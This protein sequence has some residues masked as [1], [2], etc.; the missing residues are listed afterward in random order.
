M[1]SVDRFG[2]ES[3]DIK[4]QNTSRNCVQPW[5]IEEYFPTVVGKYL[6]NSVTSFYSTTQSNPTFL[7]QGEYAVLYTVSGWD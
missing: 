3:N 5:L 4:L 1:L 7:T 2:I 6:S